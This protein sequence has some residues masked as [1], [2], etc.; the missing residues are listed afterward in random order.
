MHALQTPR[1]PGL[2]GRGALLSFS[3]VT[4]LV[5]ALATVVLSAAQAFHVEGSSMAPSLHDGQLLL[6]NKVAYWRLDGTPLARFF[7]DSQSGTPHY[8]FGGPQRGDIVVFQSPTSVE[9][10]DYVKRLIALPG[11]SVLVR[12][13]QVFV[14]GQHLQE[15]YVKFP[16]DYSFPT[17]GTPVR[18]PEGA[19]FVLGDNRGASVDSHLGW[20]VPADNLVGPS[21]AVPWTLG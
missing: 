11:D 9:D 20:F 1:T 4:A 17:D 14:N 7:T 3:L 16:D 12:E 8:V 21:L 19:Y 6:V 13:G 15:S 2:P 18:V 5:A 10:R